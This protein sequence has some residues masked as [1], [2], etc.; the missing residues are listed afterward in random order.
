MQANIKTEKKT[1]A[2]VSWCMTVTEH[3]FFTNFII[4]LIVVNAVVIGLETYPGI[5]FPYKDW[6][7]FIEKIF[8]SVFTIEII[9]RI[10]A[11]R[12]WYSFFKEGWNLFDFFI[13]ASGLIMVGG[14]FVSVLRILR[15]LRILRTISIIP[16]LRR[17]IN[18]LL[19]TIP[20]MGNI[21]FLLGLVFYIFSVI[22]TMFFAEIAP[23]YF[24]TLHASLLTLFQVVTLESWASAVMRPILEH[25][26][27]AWIYFV[28]FILIGTFVIINLFIGVIVSNMQDAH[29]LDVEVNKKSEI[30]ELRE[31]LA[32]VKALLL[33]LD[34][35]MTAVYGREQNIN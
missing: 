28:T 21:V 14:H 1:S 13:V 33:N 2:L 24:G 4:F 12:P 23:E 8:I 9:L 30:E 35:N 25:S 3:K 5:Y 10:I 32:E 22:G 6:F 7:Y 29:I 31:E 18:A 20:A 34:N 26:P 11:S 27:L 19:E 15:I 16:S 17:M